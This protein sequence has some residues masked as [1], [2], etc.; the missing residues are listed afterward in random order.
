M[1]HNDS[2]I[3]RLRELNVYAEMLPCTAKVSELKFKPVGLILGGGPYS[4]YD[5]GAPHADPA[6]FDLNIPILGICY[7]QQEL[8]HRLHKDN[9]VAGVHREYGSAELTAKSINAHVDRLFQG[10]ESSMKVWMSHGD[11]LAKLPEGFH[12]IATTK[13][14]EYAAIAHDTQPIY[15]IQFHPEVTRE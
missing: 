14:S 10:L 13:N 2:I 1:A 5:E 15:G 6:Y 3:R 9:V 7:G 4:V 12:T 11:K 8:A